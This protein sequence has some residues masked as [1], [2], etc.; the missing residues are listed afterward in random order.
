MADNWQ[1]KEREKKK[2]QLKKEKEEK[3]NERKENKRDGNDIDT[4]MAYIDENGNLSATPP[5]PA[6]KKVFNAEDIEIAITHNKHEEEDPIRTGI[7]AFFNNDKGYGFIN[8]SKN[9]ER[10]FVH[11]NSVEFPITENNKVTFE[12]QQGERG[13][14]AV[15]VKLATT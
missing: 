8:D 10:V 9:G 7:V 13:L 14:M 6:N 5:N 3:K 2:Q 11:I 4:M 12:I 1:K 15:N